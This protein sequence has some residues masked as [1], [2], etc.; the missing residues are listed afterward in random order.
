MSVHMDSNYVVDRSNEKHIKYLLL[1]EEAPPRFQKDAL[2]QSLWQHAIVA[3]WQRS[4]KPPWFC[5]PNPGQPVFLQVGSGQRFSESGSGR[6]E[7]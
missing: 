6:V 3:G 4:A 2:L 7:S 5:D 1:I